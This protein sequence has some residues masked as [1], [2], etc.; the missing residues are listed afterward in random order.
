MTAFRFPGPQCTIYSDNWWIDAGTLNR[1]LS[2]SPGVAP[3]T[4][5]IKHAKKKKPS[6]R[7]PTV[8]PVPTT[9]DGFRKAIRENEG[10]VSYMYRD[11]KGFVTVGIGFLIEDTKAGTL[12]AEGKAMPFVKRAGGEKPTVED[13][14]ADFDAVKKRP[15]GPGIEANSFRI[16][17]KLD[18]PDAE[19]K[20]RFDE[21]LDGFWTQL[22]SEFPEF[23]TYPMP[24][25]YAL[26]DMVFNLGRG[27]EKTEKGKVKRTGLHAYTTLRKALDQGHWKEAGDASHRNGPSE[28]RNKMIKQWFYSAQTPDSDH[29]HEAF[30]RWAIC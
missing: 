14:Q 8:L 4:A 6:H 23:D 27:G 12:T 25:Q 22:Q 5:Q 21:K 10:V 19:I 20:K 18:L 28:K 30:S 2:A 17:T 13:I 1:Q 16:Y 24:V 7:A 29:S 26:L 15:A 3:S 11:T 9:P